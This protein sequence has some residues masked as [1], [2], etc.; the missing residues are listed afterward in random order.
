VQGKKPWET[1][2]AELH[3]IDDKGERHRLG[4][5]GLLFSAVSYYNTFT[6]S[7]IIEI[8][9]HY[10]K[11]QLSIELMRATGELQIHALSL[12]PVAETL[13]SQKLSKALLVSWII[14]TFLL[15]ISMWH[16]L[17][18][19]P[20]LLV[21]TF[22]SLPL[23]VPSAAKHAII[24]SI[25][26]P[27]VM[28]RQQLAPPIAAA[29]TLDTPTTIQCV[30]R[31]ILEFR[32]LSAGQKDYIREQ[33]SHFLT[34]LIF[35][36]L[37]YWPLSSATSTQRLMSIFS[38]FIFASATEVFQNFSSGRTPSSSDF[39]SNCAGI[40][41][42]LVIVTCWRFVGATLVKRR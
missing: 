14:A 3:G 25:H 23:I 17:Q 13:N 37:V 32:W 11:V 35:T 31:Q 9:E 24:R 18:S 28:I 1:A 30:D 27:I 8:P 33:A 39:Y 10:D 5:T 15:I 42:G 34:F 29:A 2:R 12:K 38:L 21:L 22:G 4:T 16:Y 40:I 41:C 20:L 26:A 7:K 36:L 19:V 6:V